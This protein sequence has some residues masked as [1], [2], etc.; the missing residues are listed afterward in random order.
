MGSA[1]YYDVVARYA[2]AFNKFAF[3]I[4]AE[5][6][7]AKDWTATNYS[8]YS[9]LVG[10]PIPGD[11]SL[12]DYNGVNSYGDESAYFNVQQQLNLAAQNA[13][14]DSIRNILTGLALATPAKSGV[15]RTGYN[16]N[17]L[18]DYKAYNFKAS[19][20]FF[21]KISDNTTASLSGN[22]GTT[23]TIYTGT[24]RYNL[25]EVQIG[26]Y[27]AEVTGKNFYVRAYTTQENAGSSSD[28]VVT[29]AYLNE[30]YS[31][32]GGPTGW[33]AQYVG[34]YAQ[35]F[36]TLLA[37]GQTPAQAY[38]PASTAARDYADRNRFQ[39]GTADFNNALNAIKKTPIP[40]GG[41]FVDRTNLYAGD[42][43]Y[44]FS[45]LIKWADI[46]VGAGTKEYVLNSHGT[47]FADTAG[48]ISINETG[49]FAQI[50]KFFNDILKL[51]VAGRYD[52][53]TASS[54]FTPMSLFSRSPRII[55]SVLLFR[56]LII[57]RPIKIIHRSANSSTHLINDDPVHFICWIEH[58]YLRYGFPF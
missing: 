17:T 9:P 34:A 25:Q 51:T 11:R 48:T 6:M 24:D 32:T 4:S 8:N 38:I 45:D 42:A 43:M 53:S 3:H 49:G 26:Q 39:P 50:Q 30:A 14:N 47:I 28:M 10:Q 19:A 57:F 15:S 27:K 31:P 13:P 46:I 12:P 40:A 22:F 36:G 52:K 21:Y 18:T 1:P 29:A 7:Q 54:K 33:G 55:F 2:K 20:G 5:Y 16:E 37:L 23:N 35:A 56:P 44:N 58:K 41:E